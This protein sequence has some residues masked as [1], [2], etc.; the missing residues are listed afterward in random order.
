MAATARGSAALDRGRLLIFMFAIDIVVVAFND[1][2]HAA[3]MDSL[4]L[5]L[6]PSRC[7]RRHINLVHVHLRLRLELQL[8]RWRCR[9]HGGGG[10]WRKLALLFMVLLLE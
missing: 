2:Q 8:L 9:C 10:S 7:S 5:D 3:H 4:D 1:E 6:C